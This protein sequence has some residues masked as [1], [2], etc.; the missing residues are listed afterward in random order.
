MSPTAAQIA[1]LQK[2]LAEFVGDPSYHARLLKMPDA[3]EPES[4]A[5]AQRFRKWLA[6]RFVP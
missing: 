1:D 6:R 3:P 4:R 2:A 5:R